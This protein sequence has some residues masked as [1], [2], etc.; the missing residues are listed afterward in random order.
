M[1]GINDGI[2]EGGAAFGMGIYRGFTGL[3]TKPVEGAKSK[4][5]GGEHLAAVMAVPCP[6][7]RR[8]FCCACTALGAGRM[9]DG[10]PGC[11]LPLGSLSA[12]F[13][14]AYTDLLVRREQNGFPGCTM[15]LR[16]ASGLFWCACTDS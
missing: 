12:L 1:E 9:Q 2:V 16:S 4:G 8:L 5:V 7:S 11:I 13:G 3:V 15:S 14:C 6:C 10:L